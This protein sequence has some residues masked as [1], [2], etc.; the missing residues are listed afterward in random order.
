[1]H[2]GLTSTKARE[3]AYNYAVAL[4]IQL[5]GKHHLEKRLGKEWLWGFLRRNSKIS[6]RSSEATSLS[7]S[8]SFNKFNVGNFFD[9]AKKVYDHHIFTEYDI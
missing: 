8:T 9:N 5:N 1:M 7:R 6:L 3:L 2:Y 4:H